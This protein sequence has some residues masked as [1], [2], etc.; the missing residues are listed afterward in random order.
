MKLF[1]RPE[2]F[3]SSYPTAASDKFVPVLTNVLAALTIIPSPV[4]G[5][6]FSIEVNKT[7]KQTKTQSVML[8]GNY[9]AA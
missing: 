5:F 2:G 8:P 6:F 3:S 1:P 7:Q 4:Y 9:T